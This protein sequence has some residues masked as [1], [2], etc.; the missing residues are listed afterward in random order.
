ME[1][2]YE[3]NKIYKPYEHKATDIPYH[4]TT[5]GKYI[6]KAFGTILTDNPVVQEQANKLT[7]V[8]TPINVDLPKTFSGINVWKNY[9]SA[10]RYQGQ[11]GNCWAQAICGMLSDRF[12]IQTLGKIVVALSSTHFTICEYERDIE[13]EK[14]LTEQQQGEARRKGHQE[15]ACNGNTIYNAAIFAYR[16]GLI[17]ESCINYNIYDTFCKTKEKEKSTRIHCQPLTDYTTTDQLISCEDLVGV[18]YDTCLDSKMAARRY[19]ALAT[20][21]VVVPQDTYEEKE[22]H[23]MTDIYK[24]GPVAA[25]YD[26]YDD[27]LHGYDG[28]TIYTHPKKEQSKVGG[29][30]V[31][32]VGWGEEMQDGRL[33]KYWEI[34]NSWGPEWGMNG[35]FRMERGL[36]E[37]KLEDNVVSLVPDIPYMCLKCVAVEH[38][39]LQTSRDDE[40]RKAFGVE[41]LTGYRH[42]TIGK[43]KNGILT[44]DLKPII[45]E[46]EVP[47]YEHFVAGL[48]NEKKY[49][50]IAP[51][52]IDK[53]T[54]INIFFI[55]IIIILI[56]LYFKKKPSI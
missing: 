21:N 49:T 15:S 52:K 29:H 41:D 55:V 19:R 14:L 32:I 24:W 18:D 31:K 34:A 10:I 28:K 42:V 51:K 48:I 26:V 38:G 47:D 23:I 13:W 39:W 8:R 11:C 4:V 45:T 33:I 6:F 1:D 7:I 22:R 53:Q 43:I 20:Y 50:G 3:K 30:A 54:M 27:F 40:K 56:I 44:G 36:K 17:A 12:S 35:Y 46:N 25:G 5:E 9:L 2:V 16:Y 37:V